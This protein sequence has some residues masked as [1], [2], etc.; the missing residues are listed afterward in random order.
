MKSGPLCALLWR[1]LTWC[2]RKQ[3]TLK[4]RHIPGP[5]NVMADQLSRLGQTNQREWS[6]HPEVFK[7]ICSRWHQHQVYLFATRLYKKLPNFVSLVPNPLAW[8]LDA[9]SLSWEDLDPYAF[10]PV[11]IFCKVVEKLQD[12]PCSR[13]IL[14]A[15]GWPNMPCYGTWWPCPAR[16][17][18]V[19]PTCPVY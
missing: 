18:C 17:H 5:L 8:A 9:L 16:F 11:A 10:P 12:Y 7:V 2:S 1:I 15:P 14:I 19:C 4:A 3:V 6:L 13:I